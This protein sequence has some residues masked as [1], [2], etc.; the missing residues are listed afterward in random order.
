MDFVTNRPLKKGRRLQ[1]ALARQA[2]AAA[3]ALEE[4]AELGDDKGDLNTIAQVTMKYNSARGYLAALQVLYEQQK[5]LGQNPGPPP[6]HLGI[7]CLQRLLVRSK[8]ATDQRERA[9]R[10]ENT[11]KDSYLPSQ[12]PDH[13]RAAWECS[14]PSIGLR[15]QVD[16]LLG[17]HMLLR[18][19]NRRPLELCDCFFL[20][21][22]NE[23]LHDG[24]AKLPVRILVIT[25]NRS[26]TNQQGNKEYGAA[27]RH[28]DPFCC[29]I[30]QLAIW[31]F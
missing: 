2:A 14:N 16:F 1:Q 12:I 26:K 11:I 25:M 3:L 24:E 20:D 5:A 4:D 19:S 10:G 18:S 29:L 8:W 7:R 9:D 31:L 23:G 27:M 21:L 6:K 15:T 22:Q 13:T 28:R 17:N 30:G